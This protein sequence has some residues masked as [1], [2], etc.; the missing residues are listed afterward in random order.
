MCLH[1]FIFAERFIK[2]KIMSKYFLFLL[3]FAVIAACQ[4]AEVPT[5]TPIDPDPPGSSNIIPKIKEE[6]GG[7]YV[8]YHTYNEDGQLVEE[9]Y[10]DGVKGVYNYTPGLL[11]IEWYDSVGTLTKL[12]TMKL[13][14]KGLRTDYT[15]S[16]Q[17]WSYEYAYDT[18]DRV[19]SETAWQADGSLFFQSYF[20][21]DL[22]GN[23]VKDS[24]YRYTGE[25]WRVYR[26]E[27]YA[28]ISNTVGNANYG[29]FYF[30]QSS[31]NYRRRSVYTS[32]TGES[33]VI[34]YITPVLDDKG[35]IIDRTVFYTQSN[36]NS[37]SYFYKYTYY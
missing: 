6:T 1:A 17:T 33:S 36:G 27:Y 20:F 37:G 9:K 3:V 13:N 18:L 32:S 5:V 19:I 22:A 34:D 31:K 15:E 14:D 11:T 4:I 21:Y 26:Y 25:Q 7:D 30:G 23:L 29:K 28:D 2:N 24:V 8:G 35:R 16:G 10:N 12:I